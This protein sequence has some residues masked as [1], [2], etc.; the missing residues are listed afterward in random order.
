M[1][2]KSSYKINSSE[3]KQKLVI[4]NPS[5]AKPKLLAKGIHCVI[6]GA[7]LH[8]IEEIPNNISF[9]I[10]FVRLKFC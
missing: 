10:T 3:I 7:P 1:N 2:I 9:F 8:Y 6:T 5:P 4:P